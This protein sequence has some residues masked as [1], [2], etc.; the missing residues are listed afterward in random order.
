MAKRQKPK[1]ELLKH[2]YDGIAE[3]DNDLPGWWKNLFYITI[4]IAVIYLLH[5]HVFGT[6]DL[7]IAQY[8]KEIDSDYIPAQVESEGVLFASYR[9]PVS[10]KQIDIT[11]RDIE[12]QRRRA[13]Q[14]FERDVHNAMRS[15]DA[16]QMAKLREAF[17]EIYDSYVEMGGPLP[18][19][20]VPV[21]DDVATISEAITDIA[22]L[23]EASSLYDVHC[24]NCH[25]SSGE[26]GIG[27]NLTDEYWIYGG[28]IGQI[29]HII[30]KGVPAM[31]MIAWERTLTP[32]QVHAL[33]SFI[34]IELQGT[35]PP[36]AK[37]PQ[38]EKIMQ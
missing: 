22:A 9:S 35:N 20:S 37:A 2:E 33:A 31:G 18:T 11:P 7:Q 4:I 12:L 34:L 30:N 27:P 17:P 10:A 8:L 28:R 1:D 29:V 15:A 5:Y 6:G 36:N 24:A 3:F 25:G 16:M 32:D 26:G 14:S 38:G 23:K 21:A 19:G 13:W